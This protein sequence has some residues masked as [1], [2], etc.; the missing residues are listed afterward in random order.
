MKD[1]TLIESDMIFLQSGKT[2]Y[3]YLSIIT[4][5]NLLFANVNILSCN[6]VILNTN[7]GGQ[8]NFRVI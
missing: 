4:V 5:Y 3:I 1:D 2:I 6:C 8:I 7:S